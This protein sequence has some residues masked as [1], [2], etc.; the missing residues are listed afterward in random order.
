VHFLLLLLAFSSAQP[1]DRWSRVEPHLSEQYRRCFAGEDA[2]QGVHPAMMDCL[3]AEYGRQDERLNRTYAA[4]LRRLRPAAQSRLRDL[5]RGWVRT[6]DRQCR[7]ESDES[8]GG[9]ASD[10]AYTSCLL[11]ETVLRSRWLGSFR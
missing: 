9:Q 3:Q 10:L 11:R 4:T 8:G 2:R 5:Q 1:S 6:R 7:S